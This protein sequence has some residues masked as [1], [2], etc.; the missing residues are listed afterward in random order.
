[1]REFTGNLEF[2][3]EWEVA[4]RIEGGGLKKMVRDKD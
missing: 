2:R 3:F 1:M 4:F